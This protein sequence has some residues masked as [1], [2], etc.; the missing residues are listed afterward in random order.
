[1]HYSIVILIFWIVDYV[2]MLISIARGRLRQE[3]TSSAD[4][5]NIVFYSCSVN[6]YRLFSIPLRAYRSK[7]ANVS[8]QV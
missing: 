5:A 3:L 4:R 8:P 1:M 2:E 6:N 7:P